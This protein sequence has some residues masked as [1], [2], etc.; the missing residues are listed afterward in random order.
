VIFSAFALAFEIVEHVILGWFHGKSPAAVFA[1]ISEKGWPHLAAMTM[2]V[3]FAFLPFFAFRELGRVL[4]EGKIKE[5]FFS[6]RSGH[7]AEAP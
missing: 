2:V 3:F 7:T 4:G 6:R 1:E 5:L